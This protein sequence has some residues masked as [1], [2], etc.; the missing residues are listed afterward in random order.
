MTMD[1]PK[2]IERYAKLLWIGGLVTAVA[3][4]TL[5]L[6]WLLQPVTT[7]ILATAVIAL[8][9]A[10]VRL[11]KYSYLTQ[12]TIPALVGAVCIG[13]AAVVAALWAGTFVSDV[14]W[15]RKLPRAGLV[16]AGREVLAFV[17][18]FGPYAAV[19]AMSGNPGLSLDALP[20]AAI[21]ICLY[22]FIG[23]ALFYFTLLVRDK[24]EYVEKILILRWE[25]ISY[26]LTLIATVVIVAAVRTLAPVGWI[27]VSLALGVLGVLTRRILEEAI[28]AEDLNKVHLMEASIASNA[29]LQGSFGQIERL[30]YRLLDWADFRVYRV[31]PSGPTLAYRGTLARPMSDD[32]PAGAGPFRTEALERGAVVVVKDVR[33]EPR[34]IPPMPG[35]GSLVIHPIRFGDELLG[36]VEV[37][38]PKRHAYTNKDLMALSTLA[39]QIATAIHI[40]ELRRPLLS[41]VD[42]IGLQV[43]ALARVTESLRASA[44]AL[45]DASQGMRQGASELESFVTGGLRA[46]DLLSSATRAM[47]SQGAQAAQASGTAAAVA[48]R[49]RVVIGQAI[50]RLVGLK[51]FVSTSA[52]QVAALGALTARITG[53]IG[54]IREIADLT[55]LIALNA[56]IEAARAGA[57][58][59]GFAVVADEVRDLAAQSLHAAGEAR[60]L[61]EEIGTQ[62]T[63]VSVTMDRGRDAVAGVEELSADA[64]QALEAIVGTTSEAGR[65]AEAIAATAAEQLDAVS[66]LTGQIERV[67]AGSTRT[68][69]DTDALARRAAEAASGQSDLERAIREL[70]DV[71]SDLQ[72]IARHFA[73]ET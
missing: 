62:V 6:R 42:Q 3:A 30:A 29:T 64:A 4:M 2:L 58:G 8:R 54:T 69:S 40:A 37:D 63:R 45:A 12:S 16:N 47:A 32:P 28:G 50:D 7:V 73:V 60:T 51:G 35:I 53:F 48:G 66:G 1:L 14:L 23:R 61:L 68:R 52:D 70:G 11:S 44:L 20:A 10:P 49:N 39:N 57:E 19:L 5:D 36:T 25:I 24:L 15:L 22:F 18:A 46:T 43:T 65:H 67:A 72:R 71:A 56:A 27:A 55:N 26:L 21:L 17:A 41:T 59:R 34:V 38:H 9:A 31:G 13:P 33:R